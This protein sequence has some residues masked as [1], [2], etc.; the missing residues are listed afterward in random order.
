MLFRSRGIGGKPTAAGLQLS[1]LLL[2]IALQVSPSVGQ[3]VLYQEGFN[4][5]GDGTRY[6]VEG[7]GFGFFPDGP[8]MWEHNFL[9]DQIGLAT[10]APAKRAAILSSTVLGDFDFTDQHLEV[11]DALVDWMTDGKEN[12]NILWMPGFSDPGRGLPLISDGRNGTHRR[13]T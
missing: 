2:M 10:T 12:A 8:G 9:S 4:D 3:S 7:R 6:T 5:D 1:I 13:R 11:W